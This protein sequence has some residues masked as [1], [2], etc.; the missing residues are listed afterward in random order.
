MPSI[1]F[2]VGTRPQHIK[3]AS[4]IRAFNELGIEYNI[5]HTG[6][7]YD[8]EMDKIFFDELGIPEP[9]VH[10]GVGSGSHAEQTGKILIAIE[11]AYKELCTRLAIIPGDTNSALA[12][13]L[14]AVKLGI[15]VAH[16][17]AGLRSRIPF[18][19]EEINRV[20]LD[21]ISSLLFPPTTY[22][23]MNLIKEGIDYSKIYHVGDVMYDNIILFKRNIDKTPLPECI[24]N[25]FIYTTCH[26][27]E[28]VDNPRNL[29]SIIDAIITIVNKYEYDIVFPVHPRTY[30]RLIEYRLLDKL[31]ENKNI[32]LLK[33]VS[34]FTSLKL[35][36]NALIV[37]TDSGG[38]QKESFILGTPVVTMRNTTE[39]VETIEYGWN[40][41][42]G[43]NK[44]RIIKG[45][46]YFLENKPKKVD[47]STIYGGGKASYR[48]ASIMKKFIN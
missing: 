35:I 42:V 7:H 36:K 44:E 25:N 38:V 30:K 28:N 26:R 23:Y 19:A 4:L 21:H 33:P 11:K 18:M 1:S 48:I 27:A 5:I 15:H 17:E 31:R 6:Q 22:A 3:L 47:T 9:T 43:H 12:G 34:Y 14:A 40:I 45:I 41:L 39:W 2:V 46:E 20:V 29:K 24:E 16:V 10:L 8:Y 37:L 13:G 32:C